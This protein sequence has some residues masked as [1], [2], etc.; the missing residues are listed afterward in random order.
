MHT[1][2]LRFDDLKSRQIVKNRPTL[3][4]WI[5]LHKFPEGILLGPNTRVWPEEE[6]VEWIETRRRTGSYDRIGGGGRCLRKNP[7]ALSW[8][9]SQAK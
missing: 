6:V 2:Y 5:K 8:R 3:Y 9:T 1:S 4:R 7:K